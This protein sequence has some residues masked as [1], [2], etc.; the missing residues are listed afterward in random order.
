[1][2]I[3][4][5]FRKIISRL[6]AGERK[7]LPAPR[8]QPDP[9]IIVKLLQ[10]VRNT[11]EI[12]ISCDEVLDLLDQYVEL[13]AGGEDLAVILPFVKKHLDRCQ[14]CHEEYEALVSVIESAYLQ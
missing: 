14:D 3:E 13:Q 9:A 11:D 4:R 6:G 10:M 8:A 5:F 2:N 7:K 12:E 1:M